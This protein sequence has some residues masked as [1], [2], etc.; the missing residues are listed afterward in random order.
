V[1]D[2]NCKYGSYSIVLEEKV[3]WNLVHIKQI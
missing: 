2:Y 3:E 1:I